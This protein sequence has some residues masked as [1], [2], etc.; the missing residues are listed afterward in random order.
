MHPVP[1]IVW[2]AGDRFPNGI[3]Q[4]Q[5]RE[6]TVTG[7]RVSGG[8]AP[9]RTIMPPC[10]HPISGYATIEAVSDFK[11]R[12][13]TFLP[14]MEAAKR[15][16]LYQPPAK[17]T[18]LTLLEILTR[19]EKRALPLFDLQARSGMEPAPYANA[20]KSLEGSAYI[21]IEGQ[22]LDQ[23]VQLTDCGAEVARL[24]QPA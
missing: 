7:G 5:G 17:A 4:L 21:R 19:Q 6:A 23:V 15:E 3:G 14:F 22:G 1:G 2:F 11:P 13:G 16:R 9:I 24:S 18:P 10:K 20:L 8:S 12:P